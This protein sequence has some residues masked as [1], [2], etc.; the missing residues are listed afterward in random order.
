M[1]AKHLNK[2]ITGGY[3]AIG[4][5]A[6][7]ILPVIADG[8]GFGGGL[9]LGLVIVMIGAISQEITARGDSHRQAVRAVIALRANLD[10]VNTEVEDVR[11]DMGKASIDAKGARDS[12]Q[13]IAQ[14]NEAAAEQLKIL[15]VEFNAT[16]ELIP[17]LQQFQQSVSGDISQIQVAGNTL[18]T[19]FQTLQQQH[20]ALQQTV[21]Q[22][23]ATLAAGASAAPPPPPPAPAPEPT[24]APAPQQPAPQQPAEPPPAQPAEQ[25]VEQ[26][27]EPPAPSAPP[28]SASVPPAAPPAEGFVAAT[29]QDLQTHLAGADTGNSVDTALL[30]VGEA[31]RDDAVDLYVEPTVSLPERKPTHME[32]YGGVR[33]SDGNPLT[34]DQNLDISG[35]EALMA[36]IENALLVRSLSRIEALDT[37]GAPGAGCFYNVSAFSLGDRNFF[38][39]LIG[40]LQKLPDL[41]AKL[42]L[43]FPQAALMQHGENA[44][45]DLVRLHE[46]GVRYSIDEVTDLEIDFE[47][48]VGFGFRFAKV[49]SKFI[50]VQAKSADDPES[51][52]GLSKF[53]KGLGV[54]MIVENVDTDLSLVELIGF[55]IG[56]GQGPL[57]GPP[58][59]V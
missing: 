45:Q 27:V 25:P 56:F 11:K 34:V 58:A 12:A 8:L 42:V 33:G 49:G 14:A 43:E 26:A 40:Y 22:M 57:F 30:A 13:K 46:L 44:V 10:K 19:E 17:Q 53:L 50:R 31:L 48:L 15:Q 7:L 1:L 23:Q 9:L 36:S 16:K 4:L 29:L 41:C 51:V 5:L 6:A 2:V 59:I 18:H 24:P 52:H 28:P 20:Q 47:S 54:E 35:R 39:G 38:G 55:E 32:C 3:V 21:Q 37:G